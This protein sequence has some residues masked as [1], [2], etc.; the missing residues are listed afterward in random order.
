[1]TKHGGDQMKLKRRPGAGVGSPA[2]PKQSS[3]GEPYNANLLLSLGVDLPTAAEQKF[4]EKVMRKL[5]PGLSEPR[6]M[7]LL[8]TPKYPVQDDAQRFAK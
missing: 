8:N 4:V 6:I 5:P 7:V 1:M 2:G 3:N